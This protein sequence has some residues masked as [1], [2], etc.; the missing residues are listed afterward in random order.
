MKATRKAVAKTK[1]QQIEM[2]QKE[3][4]AKELLVKETQSDIIVLRDLLVEL[5]KTT[6]QKVKD[7]AKKITKKLLL[8]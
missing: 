8:I 1:K 5:Q 4:A 2:L 7:R 3:L 6:W